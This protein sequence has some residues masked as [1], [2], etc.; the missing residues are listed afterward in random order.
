MIF[1]NEPTQ[2]GQLLMQDR[3]RAMMSG[4]RSNGTMLLAGLGKSGRAGTTASDPTRHPGANSQAGLSGHGGPRRSYP[5]APKPGE[6]GSRFN[7]V[8]RERRPQTREPETP[9]PE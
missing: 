1:D 8:V 4:S 6:P 5:S 3:L 2:D 7:P 9:G